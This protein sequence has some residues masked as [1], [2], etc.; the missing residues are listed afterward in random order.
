MRNSQ[1]TVF[2]QRRSFGLKDVLEKAKQTKT[3]RLGGN[4][5]KR[6]QESGKSGDKSGVK[7][8]QGA[9]NSGDGRGGGASP[10]SG[11]KPQAQQKQKQNNNNKKNNKKKSF[12][13]T[14]GGIDRAIRSAPSR[15][16]QA[17]QNQLNQRGGGGA[18]MDGT[19]AAAVRDDVLGALAG[20][21]VTGTATKET[22][23]ELTEGEVRYRKYMSRVK[24]KR[25]GL[26]WSYPGGDF[27]G[28]RSARGHKKA[29]PV[30]VSNA[31]PMTDLEAMRAALLADT[32]TG[33]HSSSPSFPSSS[34]AQKNKKAEPK[35]KAMIK[36]SVNGIALKDL[37]KELSLKHAAVEEM[38]EGLGEDLSG[39]ALVSDFIID[40][41]VAELVALELGVEVERVE[42]RGTQL[43]AEASRRRGAGTGQDAVPRAPVVCIMGHVDHGKTTLLD[44]LRR[45]SV[46]DSEHGGITQ[47]LSAFSV[48][49]D[50]HQLGK[51]GGKEV[52]FLDT[53]GH[54][55]FTAMRSF[56]AQATDVVVL[57]VALDDGVRP[58][59]KEAAQ[60][61]REMNCSLV[62]AVNKVDK[63]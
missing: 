52:V 50:Q 24:K 16:Q 41:D 35:K 23:D 53:P 25:D 6:G 10:K 61:A 5:S 51:P 3:K 26:A 21:A 17:I 47:K 56:G 29:H 59:T 38:V 49:L 34:S 54:A 42:D 31:V 9:K 43:L 32:S 44:T 15:L 14:K 63:I 12:T 46:A 22:T 7:N 2:Q 45:A 4:Q 48:E 62:V 40:A 1:G 33:P 57:V 20:G 27:R 30:P 55:A 39:V 37:A 11:G 19:S 36:I 28:S 60:I 18:A 58:Q 8:G 13:N